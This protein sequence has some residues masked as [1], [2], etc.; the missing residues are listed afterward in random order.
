M[1]PVQP[2]LDTD[3]PEGQELLYLN[4]IRDFKKQEDL[5]TQYFG[6]FS[7]FMLQ[8]FSNIRI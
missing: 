1:V 6:K 4:H 3:A 7:C 2:R 8:L 5:P